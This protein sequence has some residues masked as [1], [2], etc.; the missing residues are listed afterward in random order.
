MT[1]SDSAEVDGDYLNYRL[2]NMDS[3]PFEKQLSRSRRSS[4]WWGIFLGG[5][6][7]AT[8][9]WFLLTTPLTALPG[10]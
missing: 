4:L 2:R 1:D 6:V 7:G 10:L 5:A 8:A 3:L 9:T